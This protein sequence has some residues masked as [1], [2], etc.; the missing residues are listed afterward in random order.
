MKITR[1]TFLKIIKIVATILFISIIV[2]YAL[3][4]SL[5][6]AK[7]PSITIT[8]PINGST[9]S[10]TTVQIKGIVERTNNISLNG[11]TISIDES[12][13]FNEILIVFPGTNIFRFEANDQFGRTIK[14]ELLLYAFK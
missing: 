12:G 11:R 14:K 2:I 13:N 6:Y 10:S 5:N 4:R 9:I 7:G 8:E 3:Y 1:S